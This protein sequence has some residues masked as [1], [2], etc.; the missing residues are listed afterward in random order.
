MLQNRSVVVRQTKDGR[1]VYEQSIHDVADSAD[2]LQIEVEYAGLSYADALV[3]SGKFSGAKYP[4]I[5]GIEGV[6][7]VM[8]TRNAE[9]CTGDGVLIYKDGAGLSRNGMYA[10]VVSANASQVMRLPVGVAAW[11]AAAIGNAGVAAW[12]AIEKI[13]M[14]NVPPKCEVA[15]IGAGSD[16]GAI[17]TAV[18]VDIG[19]SVTAV[20][21][22]TESK[23]YVSRL[24]VSRVMLY[25]EFFSSSGV[26][27][28]A[29]FDAD[30]NELYA[31][32]PE[33]MTNNGLL[34]VMSMPGQDIV[35]PSEVMYEKNL[36][37]QWVN[38]LSVDMQL[39]QRAWRMLSTEVRLE[40]LSWLCTEIS[41]DEIKDYLPLVLNKES[42]GRVIINTAL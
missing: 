27:F 34:L 18:L 3:L 12:M 22:K 23:D 38:P 31:E 8:G 24:G 1:V 14:F 20:I 41:M 5:A 26:Q 13:R 6:G 15:V 36:A 42:K 10:G 9:Y 11:H 4:L 30:G 33:F 40:K 32:L 39:R 37:V 17:I 28:C 2:E 16:Y 21:K 7:K 35:L 25:E 19:Y 29:V